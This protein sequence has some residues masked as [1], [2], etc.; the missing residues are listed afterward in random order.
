M[1][2][3]DDQIPGGTFGEK[4]RKSIC[5]HLHPPLPVSACRGRSGSKVPQAR[6]DDEALMDADQCG[7]VPFYFQGLFIFTSRKL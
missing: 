4:K 6:Q 1:N 5:A 7:S 3:L 2:F